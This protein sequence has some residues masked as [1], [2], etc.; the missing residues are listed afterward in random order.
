MGLC[1][2]SL[3]ISLMMIV[4]IPVLDLFISIKTGVWPICH[5]LGHE[6]MI[7]AVC[8]S[9]FLQRL[10]M[11]SD[12]RQGAL[13]QHGHLQCNEYQVIMDALWLLKL[14]LQHYEFTIATCRVPMLHYW[15]CHVSLMWSICTLQEW[16]H[17]LT[18]M[19]V[20]NILTYIFKSSYLEHTVD[21]IF[22]SVECTCQ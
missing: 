5:C 8:L 7:C 16:P 21:S 13:K 2:F 14:F 3:P 9:I 20:S 12:Q 18:F 6:T 22:T 15:M 10:D 19:L 11:A 17:T 4:R 1:V